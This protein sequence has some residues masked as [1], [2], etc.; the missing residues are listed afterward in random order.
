M[1]NGNK[2]NNGNH[3]NGEHKIYQ[4]LNANCKIQM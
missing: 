1:N 3:S 4:I 2:I